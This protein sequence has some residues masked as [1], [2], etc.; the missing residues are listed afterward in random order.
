MGRMGTKK[1]RRELGNANLLLNKRCFVDYTPSKKWNFCPMASK[2]ERR[3][4]GRSSQQR[5][6]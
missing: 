6:V 2:D 3:A 4:Y 1:I 5:S